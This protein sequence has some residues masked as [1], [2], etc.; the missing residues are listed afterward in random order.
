MPRCENVLSAIPLAID[1]PLQSAG[2]LLYR[3]RPRGAEVF[4]IHPGGPYWTRKD[5]GAWSIPKG[6]ID[7]A[8]DHLLAAR[9][10]FQEETGFAAEGDFHVLGTFRQP[11]GKRLSVWSLEGDC[12]PSKLRS[13]VFEMMWPPKSGRLQNFP[14]ADRG[15]WFARTEAESKI[16]K[17]QKP[18]LDAFFASLK[19]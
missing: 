8:E 19:R 9:R 18:V 14:E 3:R 17:G 10:E 4:L 2:I 7:P 15:G 6:L 16:V 13:N 5:E 11:G 12:D 1:M